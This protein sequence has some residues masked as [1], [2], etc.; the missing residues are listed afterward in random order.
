MD[1]DLYQLRCHQCGDVGCADRAGHPLND[2]LDNWTGGYAAHQTAQAAAEAAASVKDAAR[3]TITA[4]AR[5]IAA[6]LQT[7]TTVTDEQRLLAGLPVHDKT[8]T[9]PPVP[10]TRPVA[11]ID[12]SERMRHTINW[13]DENTPNSKGKPDGVHAAEIR[14][15]IGA[16]P[17]TD[18]DQYDFVALDTGTPYL[19]EH[20][21]ADAS[22][23]ATYILRWGNTRNEFGPW[24]EMVS[25][26]ITA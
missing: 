19:L 2:L 23:L 12:T 16:T 15:F 18:P 13:H 1:Q 3:A 9:R 10:T 14:C 25:A 11:T 7:S 21:P 20:K 8:R 6:I 17:P 22:G 4:S 26:T 24:S 5:T